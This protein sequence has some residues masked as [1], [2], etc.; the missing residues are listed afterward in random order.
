M[1]R[2]E[3]AIALGVSEKTVARYITAGRLSAHYV[4]GKTGQQLEIAEADVERLKIE[5]ET[6]IAVPAVVTTTPT[7]PPETSKINELGELSIL[8][9]KH[10]ASLARLSDGASMDS[11]TPA[12]T[13]S[14]LARIVRAV[15]EEDDPG[16]TKS[17]Q[18]KAHVG[19]ENKLLLSLDEAAALSGVS[20][21]QLNTARRDG[22]LKARR[23]GRS[24]KVRREDLELFVTSLW[25]N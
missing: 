10:S 1:T 16:Q 15:M 23:M 9:P 8:E 3:V 24:Y 6:P 2:S 19:I 25:D 17:S 7:A 4:R 5:M 14:A 20:R 12:L 13:L 11:P 22:K 21:V 18:D